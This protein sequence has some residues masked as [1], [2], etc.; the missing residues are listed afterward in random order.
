MAAIADQDL[1]LST[2]RPVGQHQM[3]QTAASRYLFNELPASQA[4]IK[5]TIQAHEKGL[6]RMKLAT[7]EIR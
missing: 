2:T 6:C 7:V 3:Q 5:V 1:H 4:T